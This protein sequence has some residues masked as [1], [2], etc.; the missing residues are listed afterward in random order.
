MAR[1]AVDIIVPARNAAA[2][3]RTTIESLQHQTFTAWRLIA[4]DDGSSDATGT[5]LAEMASTDPRIHV[6]HGPEQGVVA[7]LN[8]ALRM[9][10][11]E[12]V[13]RQDA[14]DVAWPERLERQIYYL[15]TH[16]DCVGVGCDV[17]HIDAD[18][19]PVGTRSDYRPPGLANVDFLPAQEPYVPGPFLLARRQA[20]LRIGAFRPMHV[21]EDSDLCWRLQEIGRLHNLPEVLGDYRL[22]AGS[23]SSRSIRH[24]RV[25]AV[26]SQLVAMS[27]KRRRSGRADLPVFTRAFMA[28]QDSQTSLAA[29]RD[30]ASPMLT[31][32][33]KPWFDLAISAKLVEMAMYRPFE[34]DA[35][36]CRFIAQALRNGRDLLSVDNETILT[37]LLLARALRIGF[38]GRVRDAI[39]LVPPQGFYTRSLRVGMRHG[40]PFLARCARTVAARFSLSATD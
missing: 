38:A 17:R 25:M 29:L 20:L 37:R 22:H 27:A 30:L 7:A 34:P 32:D 4:V 3:V 18:G 6:V 24:G 28:R 8:L 35:E 12:F 21:A 31:A 10:D 9:T 14:D 39:R 40:V 36:D 13:A 1:P 23:I 19:Q 2:T 15:R 33:E 5:I 26:C 16:P 11:A